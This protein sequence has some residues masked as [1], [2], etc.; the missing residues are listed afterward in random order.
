[1]KEKLDEGGYLEGLIQKYF[2]DNKHRVIMCCDPVPGLAEKEAQLESKKLLEEWQKFDN[3]KQVHLK[4]EAARLLKTQEEADSADALAT[5]PA[6]S[7]SDI[8]RE[9]VSIPFTEEFIEPI[10]YLRSP[11]NSGGIVY[12]KWA[13]DLSSFGIEDIQ[14][15]K[16]FGS[17]C[18]SVGTANKA[19]DQ[20]TTELSS[21]SGGVSSHFTLPSTKSG[22]AKRILSLS[23]KVMHSQLDENLSLIEELIKDLDFSDKNRLRELLNQQ[24]SKIQA[25][26][27]KSGEW[28]AR[29]VLNSQLSRADYLDELVSGQSYLSFLKT[30]VTEVESGVLSQKLKALKKRI[31]ASRELKVLAMTDEYLLDKVMT[32]LKRL[33]TV[34]YINDDKQRDI[35]INLKPENVGLST[36]G[37]VQYVATGINL[38]SHGI[39]D[40]PCFALLSQLL[41]TGYLWE[42]V[43]VQGGAYGCFLSYDKFE[44]M[45]NIC[46][47]R[48]P[49]L[50]ETLDAYRG[51]ADYIRNLNLSKAEFEKVFIG[52]FG[53]I[54]APL[55]VS[56]KSGVLMSRYLAGITDKFLQERRDAILN[57]SQDDLRKFS[58]WFDLLNE[59]GGICVHGTRSKIEESLSLFN[60]VEQL[61]GAGGDEDEDEDDEDFFTSS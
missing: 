38:R 1:L 23:V 18:L 39:I 2:I 11:Q 40:D 31:F 9:I 45:L 7:R 3:V 52:T 14:L 27:V 32:R 21:C 26:F 35:A 36:E 4:N 51:L 22:E 25:S 47:Y 8:K 19:F 54:D 42:K 30:C 10:T 16:L 28:M 55:T 13:F 56:Q 37:K 48:D 12:L 46:S 17:T 49:N 5:I 58:K 44:G 6:L 61:A 50:K 29:M 20:F 41:S 57:C 60:R 33:N 34:Y 53:R 24:I 43:R 59:H 15:A